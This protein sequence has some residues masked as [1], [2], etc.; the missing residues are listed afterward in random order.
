MMCFVFCNFGFE[1]LGLEQFIQLSC[2]KLG[3]MLLP[4][5]PLKPLL[6]YFFLH[7]ISIVFRPHKHRNVK[8]T[9]T[10]LLKRVLIVIAV[11]AA[12]CIL[13]TIVGRPEV[14]TCKQNFKCLSNHLLYVIFY[15][16]N[17]PAE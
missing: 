1:K 13:R 8:I 16:L 14:E 10:M 4:F 17:I 11:F 9:D 7:R 12:V 2:S 6:S 3:G 15:Q 5:A